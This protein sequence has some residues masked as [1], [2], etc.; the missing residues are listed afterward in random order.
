M[1]TTTKSEQINATAKFL[2]DKFGVIALNTEQ[3]STVIHRSI[4]TL[5]RDRAA[6]KG[7]PYTQFSAGKGKN[8]AHYNVYDIAEYMLTN[9]TKVSVR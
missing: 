2:L 3:L 5:R 1:S 4:L 7:I 6:K 9:T 8:I